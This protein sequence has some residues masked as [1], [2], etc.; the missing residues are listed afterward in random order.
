MKQLKR[1]TSLFIKMENIKNIKLINTAS[2]KEFNKSLILKLTKK[3]IN[4]KDINPNIFIASLLF[5]IKD[6]LYC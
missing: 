2:K 1:G 4:H 6:S 3:T 5:F